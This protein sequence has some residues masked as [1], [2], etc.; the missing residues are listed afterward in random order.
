MT[1]PCD[2]SDPGHRPEA[3]PVPAITAIYVRVSSRTQDTQSQEP[4]LKRW[5]ASQKDVTVRWYRDKFTGT[6]MERPGFTR[7]MHDVQLGKVNR[8]AV[9]RLDRLGRTARGLTALFED[10]LKRGVA[11]VS[12]KEGL[13]LETPAGRL[14]AH[15]LA[16]VAMFETEIRSERIVAGQAAARAAGK[17]WGGSPK[18][19]RLKVTAE[20]ETMI[21]RMKREGEA[22]TAIGRATGLSRPTVYRVLGT[23]EGSGVKPRNRPKPKPRK[24]SARPTS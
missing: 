1:A 2:L 15:V 3:H 9:W 23:K 24:R 10:L 4:D 18:G 13:D 8:V 5:A 7:L 6:T 17:R 14:L 16:S 12:L 22:I 19:R 20:Q 11:L 21:R